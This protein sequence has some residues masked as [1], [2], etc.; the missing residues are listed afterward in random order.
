ML[1]AVTSLERPRRAVGNIYYLLKL[2]RVN[3]HILTHLIP[4]VTPLSV[5]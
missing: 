4:G 2:L 5:S 1:V 3:E